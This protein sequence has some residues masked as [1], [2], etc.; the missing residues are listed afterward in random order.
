[1]YC[2]PSQRIIVKGVGV[3]T[4]RTSPR[5]YAGSP[6]PARS[7]CGHP[8]DR[9]PLLHFEVRLLRSVRSWNAERRHA[10][11]R[12][13]ST[14]GI[15]KVNSDFSCL[16]NKGQ[17][18]FYPLHI[19]QWTSL[20]GLKLKIGVG[21]EDAPGLR[22]LRPSGHSGTFSRAVGHNWCIYGLQQPIITI[23]D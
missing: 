17:C 15:Y 9:Q 22:L 5:L 8:A 11:G 12:F 20:F 21:D 16:W 13:L 2:I 14:L 4:R 18:L 3:V 1:M 10:V 6:R 23:L 7:W 19:T